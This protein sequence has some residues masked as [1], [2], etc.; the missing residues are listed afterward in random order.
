MQ[1]TVE[2]EEIKKVGIIPK[3]GKKVPQH[4]QELFVEASQGLEGQDQKDKV[5]GLLWQYQDVIMTLG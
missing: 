5:E 2:K 1:S 3:R 4:L